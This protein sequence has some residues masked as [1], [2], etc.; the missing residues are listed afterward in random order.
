M[1]DIFILVLGA[2][3][4][5]LFLCRIRTASG[6]T[7]TPAHLFSLGWGTTLL[8]SQCALSGR[9]APSTYGLAILVVAWWFFL[10]GCLLV[11]AKYPPV[12]QDS[13]PTLALR[14]HVGR[15]L[16]FSLIALQAVAVWHELSFA[17]SGG[18]PGTFEELA[19]SRSQ[20]G[21]RAVVFPGP[22]G[23]F[24][25]SHV[26]YLPLAF[27]LHG[28]RRLSG[29]LL[30]ASVI[31]AL[32][33]SLPR[34]TRAPLLQTAVVA[35]CAWTV[36]QQPSQRRQLV[37]GS[38]IVLLV[39]LFFVVSQQFI[40]QA[41]KNSNVEL[42]DAVSGYFAASPQAFD[43]L[44]HNQRL[45][46]DNGFYSL[47]FLYVP[48]EK[49]SLVESH[50]DL[51]RPKAPTFV[52]TNL[53]TFLDAYLMDFGLLGVVLGSFVTGA[54]STIYFTSATESKRL[55]AIVGFGYVMFA[56]VMASANNEFIRAGMPICLGFGWIID[57]VVTVRPQDEELTQGDLS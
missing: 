55:W 52:S 37:V 47:D 21:A 57:R 13:I 14:P 41:N 32:V 22:L 28:Q 30:C 6:T 3:V 39:S 33:M 46:D 7:S 9:L 45:F 36:V 29:R 54:F 49:L 18:I 48:L 25:W 2:A 56:C 34:F 20:H 11:H 24:R 50:P 16:L 1:S 17:S 40:L 53:Y 38:G 51:V 44:L 27:A 42:N 43:E 26:Y 35:G 8:A 15:L 12:A 23:L 19:L 5:F 31:A 4:A 10:L